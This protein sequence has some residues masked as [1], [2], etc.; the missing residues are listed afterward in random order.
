MILLLWLLLVVGLIVNH[1]GNDVFEKRLT[2]G[3]NH[4]S[5]NE[6]FISAMIKRDP[7]FTANHCIPCFGQAV[8][9]AA[10]G[11]LDSIDEEL[12]HLR[13]YLLV[14]KYS[15]K[16]LDQ[17]EED[18]LEQGGSGFVEP[19]LD[20]ESKWG[21]TVLM[22]E[23]AIKLKVGLCVTMKSIYEE[24]RRVDSEF[25]ESRFVLIQ[26]E[27]W[28]HIADAFEVL[29]PLREAMKYFSEQPYPMLSEVVPVYDCVLEIL[30]NA[31]K[32]SPSND[33]ESSFLGNIITSAEDEIK[34]L[35]ALSSD[36]CALVT[37][38]DPRM[39]IIYHK[40]RFGK[41]SDNTDEIR[42]YFTSL[43]KENYAPISPEQPTVK[44]SK[45]MEAIYRNRAPITP[46]S[47][48]DTYLGDPRAIDA[49]NFD[50]LVYWRTC[51]GLYPNLARMARDY[52]AIPGTCA[53]SDRAFSASPALIPETRSGLKADFVSAFMLLKN[54][55]RQPEDVFQD[56]MEE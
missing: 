27:H 7:E 50:V 52:L 42:Q 56:I 32:S 20:D 18:F 49:P 9:S 22:L 30:D 6:F 43:Y 11:V 55:W 46:M 1:K 10:R 34:K 41:E 36:I 45:L 37:I 35:Y 33:S 8:N 44:R 24:S 28:K 12:S 53:P 15:P 4:E 31:K 54:W 3:Q 14:I 29:T 40:D 26:D 13:Q 48:L 39:K 38:L 2:I 25:K 21:S 17:L 16:Y 23:R 5:M 19:I 51:A 47:E